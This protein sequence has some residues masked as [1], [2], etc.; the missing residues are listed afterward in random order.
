MDSVPVARPAP[1]YWLHLLLLLLTVATTFTSYLLYFHFQRPYSPDEVS[2][3]AATRALSFSLSLLAILGSHEMGHYVLAR[4]HRV[5]TSLP[6]FIP[7]P[8]LGVGTLGAVI[9][10]RDRIPHRNAL[11]DIGAAGPLAGLV[12]ALPILY[13]GLSHSAVVDAPKVASQFPGESSLW[14]YGKELF[15][16][17]MAKVTHAPPAPEQAFHGVQ[18]LFGD[19]LLMQ[20]LTW[21]ALGPLPEGKDVLVHPVVIAGW[22]GLLVTLL[23]LMPMGQLDGGHLAF[24]VLGRHAHWVGRLMAAVLLFLTLFVTASWGLWLLVT[25]KVVGFGHP[26][27]VYPQEPLSPTRKLICALCLLALIGCAMPV[28]LR[29]VVS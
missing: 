19:S 28:P 26:E 10:I 24:A 9:R 5:D 1:R 4:L 29:Q 8:V 17:V 6:Y 2:T 25:S 12:V 23:N 22:F 16:W 21:L 11:V 14:V 20:G 13:W 15:T 27:V 7:L 18:T 3:E